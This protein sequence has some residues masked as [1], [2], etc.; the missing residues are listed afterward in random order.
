MGENYSRLYYI[1]DKQVSLNVYS[2][3]SFCNIMYLSYNYIMKA[4][5]DDIMLDTNYPIQI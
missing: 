4:I 5:L 2:F 3:L 1:S